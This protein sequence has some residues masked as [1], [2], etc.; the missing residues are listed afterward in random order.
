MHLLPSTTTYLLRINI[1]MPK[2][3]S[4]SRPAQPDALRAASPAV[5]TRTRLALAGTDTPLAAREEAGQAVDLG[6]GARVFVH[7]IP[8]RKPLM[9]IKTEN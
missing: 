6:A 2:S 3:K 8:L 1:N 5:A 9:W 4:K 7:L